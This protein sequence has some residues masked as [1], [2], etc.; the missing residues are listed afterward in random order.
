MT[1]IYI[2]TIVGTRTG[3][4]ITSA[5]VMKRGV[6]R[7]Q[8]RHET[9]DDTGMKRGVYIDYYRHEKRGQYSQGSW[10]EWEHPYRQ[11]NTQDTGVYT[12]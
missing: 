7:E 12:R 2:D 11:D 10:H 6:Q 9:G 3:V 5:I 4:Y 1:C 8:Y